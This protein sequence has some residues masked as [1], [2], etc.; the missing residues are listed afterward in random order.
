[1]TEMGSL[2]G[3][4]PVVQT[5]FSPDGS[6]DMPTMRNELEWVLDQGVAGL[7][8]GMV[9]EVLRLT[10]GERRQLTEIV[11]HVATERGVSSVISCGAESTRTAIAHATHAE[12][13]GASALMAI[14]PISVS[15]EDEAVFGYFAAIG[16]AVS[17]DL[18]VQDASGYVG[19]PLSIEVQIRLLERFGDRI[20]FKPEAPPIGQRLSMLRDASGGAAR[21]FEGSGGAA[22]VDSYRRGIV[23]TM[24]GA[25]V[26]WAIQRMWD[27]LTEGDWE[28]AYRISGP[29]NSLVSLQTSI[30][31]YVA[32]EKYLLQK[33]G[34][35][36][37]SDARGPVGFVLDRE[38]C[39]EID[40][41]F[42][43]LRSA[44]LRPG[45]PS[46]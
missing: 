17:I 14:P 29:L 41:L 32:V 8:T 46:L 42:E 35:I 18:V 44:V 5:L 12:R 34:V 6:I 4:L 13:N 27:A 31:S 40:Q 15:L 45:V 2:R 26:C 9:S 36:A 28:T 38:T 16:D 39:D 7:T 43:L 3:V 11:T 20:Y 10:E 22:L 19:R 23:G 33:Q 37:S 1:M 24:P 21:A 25:E 30:D